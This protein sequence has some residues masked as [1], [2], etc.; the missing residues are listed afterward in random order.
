MTETPQQDSTFMPTLCRL[1]RVGREDVSRTEAI[2]G[3]MADFSIETTPG[4]ASKVADFRDH[5]PKGTRVAV[6]FL[7][8]GDWRDTAATAERLA[9]EEMRPVPHIAARS[10]GSRAELEAFADRIARRCGTREAVVLAGAVSRPTGPFTS[11]MD[12]LETGILADL[13]I[14]R[15]GVAGHPE[16]S[17]DIRQEALWSALSWKQE[18]AARTGASVYICTQ[19]AFEAAPIIQWDAALRARGITLPVRVGL[20]GL[21]T[22]KTLMN[23]AR[24]CGIGPSMRF[25]TKQAHQVSKLM[26]VN[27]PDALVNDLAAHVLTNPDSNIAGL[28]VYPLGGF[29]KSATWARAVAQGRFELTDRGLRVDT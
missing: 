5:L 19:F 13:G 24:A 1:L 11:S 4:G 18:Y 20:P 22:L 9:R 14:D 12:L 6:T 27:A 29:E 23:H 10:L 8:G 26:T 16:G 2:R 28:H 15:I 7:P 3:L 21:A 17:P 25:L